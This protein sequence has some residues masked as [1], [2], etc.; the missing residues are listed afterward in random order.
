MDRRLW[1]GLL[2]LPVG[3]GGPDTAKTES[4]TFDGRLLEIANSYEGYELADTSAKIVPTFCR[5][6]PPVGPTFSGSEDAATHGRKLYWLFVKE[7]PPGGRFRAYTIDGQASPVGQA[8]VKEAWSPE[9]GRAE[10]KL[11][12]ELPT[13]FSRESGPV[14]ANGRAYHAGK[15]SGLFIMFKMEPG[16]PGT[17]EGWVYGTVTADGKTVTS[18]GRVE[19]CMGCHRKAPHDRLFGL[20]KE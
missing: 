1:L 20:H 3:C 18:S 10:G 16:T 12:R 11:E 5:L 4:G 9:E 17:D 14:I 7:F 2:M 15:K 8:V 19:S 6:P 13:G